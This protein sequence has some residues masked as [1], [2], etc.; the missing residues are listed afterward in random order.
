MFAANRTDSR[1]FKEIMEEFFHQN[2]YPWELLIA[3]S[4]PYSLHNMK[5]L[6]NKGILP[7]IRGR[8]N[9]TS[10]PIR[11]LKKGFFFNTEFIPKGWSDE[12][13]LK[14][15]SFRPMIEQGNSA[16]HTYYNVFRMNTRGM[17]AA[18]RL[19]SLV[20][21]L[22]LLKALTAYKLGRTE[23]LMKPTAF[24]GSR[25][26]NFKVMLP[27]LARDSGYTYFNSEEILRRR[28]KEW[29]K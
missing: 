23:L 18:I 14:I 1:A 16:N 15:Y 19:R 17:D 3:D 11:Q 6:Q 21:S 8:K 25:H 5:S 27:Y 24:E 13:L 7:I 12:F 10:Q 22:Q 28:I 26:F 9:L 2:N 4:G 20:Y 29:Y